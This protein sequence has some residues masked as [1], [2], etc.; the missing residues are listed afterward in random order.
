MLAAQ[1]GAVRVRVS[2]ADDSLRATPVLATLVSEGRVISQTEVMHGSTVGL[3][4]PIGLVDL[5]AEA[6]GLVTEVRRGVHAVNP[7]LQAPGM[8][9]FVMRAGQ[10]VRVVEYAEGGLAREEVA[11]RLRELEAAVAA[12]LGAVDSLRAELAEA[13][14]EIARIETGG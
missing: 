14:E 8:V 9:E 4:G 7:A 10:G 1:N 3:R 11:R 13:R 12:L 6:P 5:R 2:V